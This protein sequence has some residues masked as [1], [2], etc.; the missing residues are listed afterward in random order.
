MNTLTYLHGIQNIMLILTKWMV[1]NLQVHSANCLL[2]IDGNDLVV[3]PNLE[4][5]ILQTISKQL[6]KQ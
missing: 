4:L 3:Q 6:N 1:V 5:P 2:K